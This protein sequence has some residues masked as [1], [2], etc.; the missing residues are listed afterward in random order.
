[1]SSKGTVVVGMSGGVDSSVAAYLLKEEGYNVIGVTMQIWP[2]EEDV[3]RVGGCCS[4]S[5]VNDA[6]RVADKL[7]IPFYVMNF[8]DLFE[9]EVIDYFTNEYLQGRTPNPCI[10]CNKKIKFEGFLTKAKKLG[11]DYI[12][13]GHYANLLFDNIKKR[14]VLKKAIDTMKDQTYALYNFTQEQMAHTLLPLGNYEKPQIREI[15]ASIGLRVANKPDSQEICFVTDNNYKNFIENRVG[16]GHFKPGPFLDTQGNRIGTHEGLPNYTIGQRKGLGLALGYPVYVVKID[17]EK[18]TVIVGKD[19]EVFQKKLIADQNNYILYENLHDE[20]QIEAKIR[21]S[22]IPAKAILKPL[23]KEK[24]LVEFAEAQRAIT[25]G[26][27][28]VYYQGDCVVGG[29]TIVEGI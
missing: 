15:A 20:I 7:E 4:L 17:V 8:R 25:P 3:E 1:M 9:I 5:A 23:N 29:G 24:V 19:N 16:Q 21:Y 11:A 6:R 14:F 18:N 12:A 27:A 13:T 26:Q 10:A 2:V 22:A 28:V